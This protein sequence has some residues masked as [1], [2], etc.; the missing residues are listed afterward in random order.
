VRPDNLAVPTNL[1]YL[2]EAAKLL[3]CSVDTIRR[4]IRSGGIRAWRI[5]PTARGQKRRLAVSRLELLTM[6]VEPVVTK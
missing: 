2:D 6:C 3:N 4:W 1:I 5:G